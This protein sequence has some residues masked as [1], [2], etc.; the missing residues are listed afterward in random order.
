MVQ[1]SI[2]RWGENYD[3]CRYAETEEKGDWD[4][5]GGEALKDVSDI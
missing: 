5:D 3:S 1:L 4:A 2:E